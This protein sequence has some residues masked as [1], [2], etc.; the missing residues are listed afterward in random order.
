[1]TEVLWNIQAPEISKR[2]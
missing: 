1:M 2:L